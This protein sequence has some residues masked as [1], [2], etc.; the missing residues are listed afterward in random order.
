MPAPNFSRPKP[1]LIMDCKCDNRRPSLFAPDKALRELMISTATCELN[2]CSGR[3]LG[4]LPS[5]WSVELVV[6]AAAA[7]SETQAWFSSGNFDFTRSHVSSF[8]GARGSARR[9]RAATVTPPRWRHADDA[10]LHISAPAS[11]R[12]WPICLVDVRRVYSINHESKRVRS[13]R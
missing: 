1:V 11:S 9:L 2:S 13:P 4:T 6:T 5:S 10:L 7:A 3:Q 12:A 8:P